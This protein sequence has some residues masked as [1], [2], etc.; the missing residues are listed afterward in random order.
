MLLYKQ[1]EKSDSQLIQDLA[2]NTIVKKNKRIKDLE[3]QQLDIWTA[4]MDKAV[5]DGKR[6]K[7][8]LD[9]AAASGSNQPPPPPDKPKIVQNPVVPM[10]SSQPSG[11]S[12]SG[13][14]RAV[15]PTGGLQIPAN[16]PPSTNKTR[17]DD[18]PLNKS[19]RGGAVPAVRKKAQ[20]ADSSRAK[21][22]TR[23]FQRC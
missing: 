14:E 13:K 5:A 10:P 9:A 23:E 19:M 16:L 22:E 11:V 21:K 15:Q 2:L 4:L 20:K 7:D 17:E 6:W 18:K 8:T 1:T 12:V 3:V